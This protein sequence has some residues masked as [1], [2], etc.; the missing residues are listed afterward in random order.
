MCE[1]WGR[2]ER[3]SCSPGTMAA[4]V[5]VTFDTDVRLVL[6]SVRAPTLV[7]HRTGDPAATSP[8]ISRVRAWW[9]CPASTTRT[10]SATGGP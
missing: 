10:S 5:G 3:L 9:R 1:W 2:W 7:I 8:R 4:I 6:A